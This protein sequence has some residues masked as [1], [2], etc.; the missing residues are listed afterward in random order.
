[1]RKG[2][3]AATTA[4]LTTI[5]STAL[6]LAADG[7]EGGRRPATTA[8]DRNQTTTLIS[9]AR[10]GGVPNGPSTNGVISGDKRFARIIAFQS[11]ASDIVSGDTNGVSDVFFR[12]RSGRIGNT[13]RPWRG[14]RA[15]LV[16]RG[17]G[18]P[19]DGPSFS[20]AVAGAF[21]GRPRCVAFL[22]DASNLVAGDTN[23]E[24]DAFVSRG[25]GRRPQRVSL[26]G[27]RQA[28]ADTTH[29]AVNGNCSKIAFVT[30][31][32]LYV[33]RGS[34][35]RLLSNRGDA[36]DPSFAQGTRYDLVFADQGGIYLSRA[37]SGRPRRIVNGGSNPAYNETK[38]RVVA[39]EKS[40]GGN[41]Q[42]AFRKLGGG[43]KFASRRGGALG[44]G[45]S[46]DPVIANSGF[47]VTFESEASNLGVS[48]S[49]STGDDNGSPDA[50]LFSDV[51]NLTL[52]Q[53]VEEKAVAMPGGGQNPS[54]SWY[55]NYILFDSPAPLG[56]SDDNPRQVF[57]RYLGG[58]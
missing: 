18:G 47:Y 39:Y 9:R 27:N 45:D 14:R 44:N 41:T 34:R 56:T 51:R 58:I 30:G 8:Q 1:M 42:I 23:G 17:R 10:D 46:R 29:V 52:L 53:S 36:A 35:T 19:A 54:M 57:M 38:N 21:N 20:P 7:G 33:R 48:A 55:A 37:G 24:T 50:Y 3:I 15:R 16:S 32:R 4:A 13:G 31:G 49:G 40:A 25:P 28:Q 11:E 5:G 2:T 12:R 6:A 22:S 43:E 26:P